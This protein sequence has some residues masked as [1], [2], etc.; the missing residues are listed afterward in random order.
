[1][2][3][4][5]GANIGFT[6]AIFSLVNPS[7]VVYAVEPGWQNHAFLNTNIQKNMLKNIEPVN[8]AIADS[9]RFQHFNE[10]SAWGFL[11]EL[12]ELNEQENT[13][14]VMT[15]DSFVE[16]VGLTQLDLI[17]IDVEGFEPFV[18]AGMNKSIER[19]N[20]KIIFEFNSFCMLSFGKSNPIDFMEMIN[21][22]F[23]K[24]FRFNTGDIENNLLEPVSRENFAISAFHQN[25]VSDRSVND[26]YVYN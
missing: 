10:N 13:T 5:I 11:Q 8:I 19:F 26:Y 4:D 1:V 7:G 18:F 6:S 25:V 17:K 22:K 23:D 3:I 24:I 20:P 21:S 9:N 15:L 2:I 12:D 14:Q 16:E